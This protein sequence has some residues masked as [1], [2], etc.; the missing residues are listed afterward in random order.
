MIEH[1]FTCPF[2]FTEISIL[3]DPSV[4]DQ[5]YIEDCER[6]CR[7]IEFSIKTNG[8]ELLDV[9]HQGLAQ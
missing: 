2:C 3:I 8:I 9:Q 4:K 5:E 1:F 7:P 6:C